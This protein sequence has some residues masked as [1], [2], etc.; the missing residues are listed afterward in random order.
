MIVLPYPSSALWPNGRA[1]WAIKAREVKKHRQW[2]RLAMRSDRFSIADN[3]IPIA[4]TCCPKARGPA[5][6]MDSIVS[7]AKSYIDGIADY[8]GINDRYFAAPTVTIS[9]KRTG[10]F[11]ITVGET[12]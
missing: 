6:D 2:A 1:H 9:D 4:I 8:L 12:E 11:I 7:A 10:Q 3:P 5:P